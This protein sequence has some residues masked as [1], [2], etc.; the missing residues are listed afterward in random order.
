MHPK[1]YD[2]W[3]HRGLTVAIHYDAF[4]LD[5]RQEFDYYGEEE[6]TA[7]MEGD[8]FGFVI[9]DPHNEHLDSCWGFYGADR[10]TM[11]YLREQA[12]AAADAIADE[13]QA[14]RERRAAE[15]RQAAQFW[16][17]AA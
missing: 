3:Q 11:A 2:Q 15:L 1:P 16:G 12:N 14:T 8:V 7:Y 10:E 9:S 17:L 13:R 6:V 5:P 4:P